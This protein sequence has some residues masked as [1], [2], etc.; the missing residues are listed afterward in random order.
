MRAVRE[1]M[2]GPTCSRITYLFIIFTLADQLVW[3]SG[4]DPGA[5]RNLTQPL[6]YKGLEQPEYST[7]PEGEFKRRRNRTGNRLLAELTGNWLLGLVTSDLHPR[8][9]DP[10]ER[11][12]PRVFS[13]ESPV[14]C[15]LCSY[16][17]Q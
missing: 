6:S 3:G 12:I 4:K 5:G 2:S 10:G 9:A 17:S 16:L 13:G 15:Y 8:D 7:R 1:N 14:T 11:S